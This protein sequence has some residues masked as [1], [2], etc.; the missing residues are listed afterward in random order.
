[1]YKKCVSFLPYFDLNASLKYQE[2]KS[3]CHFKWIVFFVCQ[4]IPCSKWNDHFWPLLK[5]LST[6]MNCCL[7]FLLSVPMFH[8]FTFVYESIHK[9]YVFCFL[10]KLFIPDLRKLSNSI[11]SRMHKYSS[12]KFK[13]YPLIIFLAL[14]LMITKFVVELNTVQIQQRCLLVVR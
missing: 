1:M 11:K 9:V 8:S 10:L 3:Q 13:C 2:E 5:P 4:K 6:E 14:I 7:S 12:N